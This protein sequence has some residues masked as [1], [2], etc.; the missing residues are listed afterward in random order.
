MTTEKWAYD[1]EETSEGVAHSV[2][3]E[4]GQRLT[5]PYISESGARLI[6]AAP[7]LLAAL[8]AVTVIAEWD[9]INP[10]MAAATR[11]ARSVIALATQV[12][13]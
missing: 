11:Y 13:S 2:Y 9:C 6:A 12:Q 5:E 1:A 4:Q 7:E 8:E 10:N 3:D